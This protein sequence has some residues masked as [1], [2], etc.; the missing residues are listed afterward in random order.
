MACHIASNECSC[1]DHFILFIQLKASAHNILP[2]TFWVCILYSVKH[3]QEFS[4][5]IC[6][7][8][9]C[10]G[11]HFWKHSHIH[12]QRFVSRM[13]LD[14]AKFAIL[15]ITGFIWKS[16]R[17]SL[18]NFHVL[19][20]QISF[21]APKFPRAFSSKWIARLSKA[22]PRGSATSCCWS[23]VL[24]VDEDRNKYLDLMEVSEI[25]NKQTNKQDLLINWWQG[26]SF[27]I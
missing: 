24:A 10:S 1:P 16:K 8:I 7:C 14:P 20:Q 23:R 6:V 4:H 11:K 13:I 27:N 26:K 12:G 5:Y 3:F 25:K 15:T 21:T 18:N 9:L 22:S 17:D 2:V 19:K